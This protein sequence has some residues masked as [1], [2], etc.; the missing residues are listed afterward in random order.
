MAHA[1][2]SHLPI[3]VREGLQAARGRDRRV[4]GGRLRV[5]MGETWYPIRAFDETG[6][7]VGLD[8]APKLRG[9]VEIH[10]GPRVVRTALI[11]AEQPRD[12]VMRYGFK[13]ITVARDTAPL[14]Y[15]R[16]VEAPAGYI[17]AT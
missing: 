14:D 4:T 12:G 5:Q 10:D 13:R 6:F 8:V 17:A 9:R 7:D 11:V 15:E 3:E 16:I 1:D 2:L